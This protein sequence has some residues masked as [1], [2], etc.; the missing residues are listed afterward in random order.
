MATTQNCEHCHTR[1]RSLFCTLKEQQ[2]EFI[3]KSKFQTRYKPGQYLFYS[4]NPA[5]GIF[6]IT[7]GTIK[8]ESTDPSGKSHLIQIFSAGCLIGYRA[9]FSEEP[10]QSSA[11]VIEDAEVCYIPKSTLL[12]LIKQDPSL[13][14][15]FLMQLSNDFRLMEQRLQRVSSHSAAERIAEALL[16]LRE[17]FNEKNWTRKEIAEWASTT[18]ETVIR[19]LADFETEGLIEQKGRAIR[20]VKRHKLLERARI[21][22]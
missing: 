6:C 13:A 16:F 10:Y 8:L 9:L 4:G 11:I 18:P 21:S 2:L 15:N 7:S 1:K 17:N 20:I 5:T 3:D 14:M 19:T 12:E 22:F